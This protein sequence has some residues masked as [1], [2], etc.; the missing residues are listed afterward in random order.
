M[1]SVLILL[2]SLNDW[3]PYYETNSILSVS[4]YL[5]NKS[6][7]NESKLV[8]NL[9][10]DLS[11]NSEGYYC[12]L[13]AQARGH[14]IIPGIETINKLE[15]GA[16]VRMDRSLQKLCYQYIQKNNITD[17]IWYLNI[18][19]GTC[20]EKG[21]EKIA[22]FI[23]DN[24]PCPLLKVGFNNK[25]RNQIE[26]VQ[27]LS[28]KQ[29]NNEEQDYFANALDNFNK[30]VWRTPRSP[31]TS[32]YS[33][34]I[35]YNPEEKF[36]PSNKRALNKFLE[37]SKKM[38]IYAELITEEDVTR[39]MEF[40]ALFI[41]STT[42]LHHITFDLSQKAMLNDMVV[43]DDPMSIIRC[44][45][46]VY[47]NELLVKEKIPAP[48]SV[49][50]FKSNTNSFNEIGDQLGIPFILKIPDGSFSHGIKKITTEDEL[51]ITLNELFEKSAILLAQEFIPTEFDWRIGILNGEPL[52]ACKYF[53][54]KGHWQ[55]YYHSI[56][57]K[58]SCGMVETVPIYKVPKN[59]LKTAI[60][61]TSFIGKGLYGVDLKM[62]GEKAIVIEINDNP[63]ID[64]EIE[65]AILGDEL[66]YRILN[67]FVRALEL[68]HHLT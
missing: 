36:P 7:G 46:K 24:Y 12:S 50:I 55:I 41:R 64:Y 63:N 40:D 66:Y 27:L 10:N 16:G 8:I 15:S 61:A 17:E 1:N 26:T 33:L 35:L 67:Y 20:K 9:S 44:T 25:S 14:K 43:I 31:K 22:R 34:A 48:K 47:L 32:R 53:M 28:L 13:L 23:F 62:V 59:I 5:K 54:A 38:N 2:C 51:N 18:Y 19:F 42:A 45:N 39:L 37:I 65:D 3:K 29:L 56:T 21:L 6:F 57:G 4:E 60:K 52:Y 30:K 68:K 49:L 11:Y 58:S